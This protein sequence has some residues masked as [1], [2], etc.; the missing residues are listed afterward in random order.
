MP[1]PIFMVVAEK[2]LAKMGIK[3]TM[4]VGFVILGLGNILFSQFA[5]VASETRNPQFISK[6]KSLFRRLIMSLMVGIRSM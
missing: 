5:T 1:V 6:I 3:M 2:V 4:V